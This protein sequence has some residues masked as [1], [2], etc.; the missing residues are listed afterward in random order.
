M[1]YDVTKSNGDR[2]T[3]IQD[4]EVDTDHSSLQLLGKNYPGYG[5]IM[6][7]NLVWLLENFANETAPDN[8][9]VGQLW[10][11]T[12]ADLVKLYKGDA[13][14]TSDGWEPVNPPLYKISTKTGISTYIVQASDHGKYLRFTSS[15]QVTLPNTI[16]IPVGTRIVIVNAGNNSVS[17]IKD[18]TSIVYPDDNPPIVI[19]TKWGRVEAVK[20]AHTGSGAGTATWEVSGDLTS[21]SYSIVPRSTS[22]NE[23]QSVIY[24]VFT[25]NYG[26]G[27]LYWSIVAGGTDQVSSADIVGGTMSGT[28]NVSNNEGDFTISTVADVSSGE[29]PESLIVRLYTDSLRTNLVA[30]AS[31][32]T[33]NDTSVAASPSPSPTPTPSITPSPGITPSPT[34]TPSNSSTAVNIVVDPTAKTW[35]VVY[36][37]SGGGG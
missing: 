31:T 5:E 2:L 32:V 12:D 20:T 4:R 8:P 16:N 6:A 13:A 25:T 14:V 27:M 15:A 30:T 26:S 19:G 17:I 7:E 11:D 3:F 23:G 35:N 1:A 9:L 36:P 21:I 28:V 22:I 33:V 29:G 34:P 10:Y 18:S 24:D 37:G